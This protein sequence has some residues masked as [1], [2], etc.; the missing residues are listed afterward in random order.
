MAKYKDCPICNNELTKIHLS[1]RVC[2]SHSDQGWIVT[3]CPDCGKSRFSITKG[4]CQF[5]LAKSPKIRSGGGFNRSRRGTLIR[6][7][8][9]CK[10]N[11]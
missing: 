3:R 1:H 6:N 8:M 2:D 9:G 10:D 7:G 4:V 5:C 11:G